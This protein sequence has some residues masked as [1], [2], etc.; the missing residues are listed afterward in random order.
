MQHMKNN[1]TVLPGCT[2]KG[3]K[4]DIVCV[5][6]CVCVC[7]V[8]ATQVDSILNVNFQLN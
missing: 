6:V 2:N 3:S 7:F 8:L 5:C 1:P 4:F